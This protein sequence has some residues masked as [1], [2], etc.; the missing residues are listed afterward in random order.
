MA[1][2]EP[3]SKEDAY[4]SNIC[5]SLQYLEYLELQLKELRMTTVIRKKNYKTYIIEATSIIETIFM[6]LISKTVKFEQERWCEVSSVEFGERIENGSRTK[7]FCVE[8]KELEKPYEKKPNFQTM[9]ELVI[10][11]NYLHQTYNKEALDKLRDKRNYIH[12]TKAKTREDIDYHIFDV[13][14]FI[15]ARTLLFNLLSDSAFGDLS[16]KPIIAKGVRT[17]KLIRD[18]Y[19]YYTNLANTNPN[20]KNLPIDV[21]IWKEGVS[22]N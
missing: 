10:E 12:L 8:K 15:E 19:K 13:E 22:K 21:C 5:Y 7:L 17:L 6:L 3:K 11:G 4:L 2:I 20:Y 9:I 1:T 14:H 16:E 18:K